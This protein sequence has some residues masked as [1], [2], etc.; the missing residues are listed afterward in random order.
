MLQERT[1]FGF[2]R[3]NQAR[4]SWGSWSPW[5]ECSRSCGTGIQSQARECV[6]FRNVPTFPKTRE[7]SNAPSTTEEY[8]RVIPT[9][10][11]HFWTL[12]IPALSTVGRSASAFTPLSSPRCWTG[13]RAVVHFVMGI[14]RPFLWT[15]ASAGC[16]WP[17]SASRWA[18][19]ESWVQESFWTLVAFAVGKEGA[20]GS[21]RASSWSPFCREVIS[22]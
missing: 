16:A 1:Q 5:S 20:A 4:G 8:T 21:S 11:Y 2:N 17:D 9:P 13:H 15:G 19:T 3:D 7:P 22:R 14:T 10:G 6:P 18:V 12:P